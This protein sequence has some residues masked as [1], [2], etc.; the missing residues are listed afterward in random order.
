VRSDF[1]PAIH[2]P[3]RQ[4]SEF[5]KKADFGKIQHQERRIV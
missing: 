1:G 5:K 3:D 4:A 2:C